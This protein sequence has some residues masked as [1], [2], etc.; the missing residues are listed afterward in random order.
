MTRGRASLPRCPAA[1]SGETA[2]ARAVRARATGGWR[3]LVLAALGVAP[4]ACNAPEQEPATAE[5][6]AA[7]SSQT[8]APDENLAAAKVVDTPF[9]QV[10]IEEVDLDEGAH[11]EGGRLAVTYLATGKAYP[12]AVQGGSFG[13][14]GEWSVDQRF[15]A[16]PVIVSSAGG[17]GQGYTCSTTELTELRPEGPVKL[18]SYK[19]HFDNSGV[20]DRK[21]ES[22]D[23]KIVAVERDR[24][25]SVQ[26]TGTRQ[27][28]A[29]YNRKGNGYELQGGDANALQGC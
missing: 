9:G 25:F 22:V 17:T 2:G 12:Q 15:S 27:F 8:I 1:R 10:R 13:T 23:G 21:P 4:A 26:F 16:Y 24:S 20:P 7:A 29:V 5:T 18:V 6:V 11:V 19:D 3:A 28:T 14:F